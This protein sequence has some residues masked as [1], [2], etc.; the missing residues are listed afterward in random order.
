LK[1]VKSGY[2]TLKEV[3]AMDTR[4]VIQALH[5]EKFVSDYEAE[6]LELNKAEK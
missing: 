6:Y 4:E 3:R 5:Y 1:L 2:G